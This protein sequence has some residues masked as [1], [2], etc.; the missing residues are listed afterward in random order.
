MTVEELEELQQQLD[1]GQ[2]LDPSQCA[3]LLTEVWRL[4]T[5]NTSKAIEAR[6]AREESD[7]AT[8]AMNEARAENKALRLEAEQLQAINGLPICE[9]EGRWSNCAVRKK[10]G[11]NGGT[12]L[13][14]YE[15]QNEKT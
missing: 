11:T 15:P 4:K 13:P 1:K 6:V 10:K 2:P 8:T 14:T 9:L 7:Q 3:A 5:V 12:Q